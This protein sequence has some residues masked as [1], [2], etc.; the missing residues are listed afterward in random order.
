MFERDKIFE[1]IDIYRERATWTK[2][3][4]LKEKNNGLQFYSD[5]VIFEILPSEAYHTNMFTKWKCSNRNRTLMLLLQQVLQFGSFIR[6]GIWSK[7]MPYMS[8]FWCIYLYLYVRCCSCL[9][10]FLVAWVN[11]PWNGKMNKWKGRTIRNEKSE[12]KRDS[13]SS[14]ESVNEWKR[15]ASL[16]STF[17]TTFFQSNRKFSGVHTD[18]SRQFIDELILF[19]TP[20]AGLLLLCGCL[21]L[22]SFAIWWD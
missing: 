21:S 8:A 10:N 5:E 2:I 11:C 22:C 14:E 13:K 19:S 15:I 17:L 20:V 1:W 12:R 4:R 6:F 3:V 16:T 7:L 18:I 9:C